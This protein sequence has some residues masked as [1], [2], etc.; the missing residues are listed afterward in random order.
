MC[1]VDYI[2]QSRRSK[3]AE[4]AR[5]KE[6]SIKCIGASLRISITERNGENGLY[7]RSGGYVARNEALE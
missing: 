1:D 2:R 5:G 6:R 4:T 3:A 7:R